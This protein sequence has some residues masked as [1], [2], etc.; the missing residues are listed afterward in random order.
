MSNKN[1]DNISKESLADGAC[2][3]FATGPAPSLDEQALSTEHESKK[4]ELERRERQL[5]QD[6]ADFERERQALESEL[7]AR[8]QG[9]ANGERKLEESR[10]AFESERDSFLAGAES[11]RQEQF[12][13]LGAEKKAA[14]EALAEELASARQRMAADQESL[15]KAWIELENERD[16]FQSEKEAMRRELARSL[17][18]DRRAAREA[19]ESELK[20]AREKRMA[21]LEETISGE[22]AA[23]RDFLARRQREAMQAL[24]SDLQRLR[25]NAASEI[26]ERMNELEATKAS[27]TAARQEHAAEKLRMED[28]SVEL[29]AKARSLELRESGIEREIETRC[30]QIKADLEGRNSML[31]RIVSEQRAQILSIQE[32]QAQY[33]TLR[34]RLGGRDPSGELADLTVYEARIKELS[35]R[36]ATEPGE[37]LMALKAEKD[38]EIERHKS[39]AA[40]AEEHLAQLGDMEER[41]LNQAADLERQIDDNRRL[42]QRFQLLEAHNA[43]IEKELQRYRMQAGGEIDRDARIKAIENNPYTLVPIASDGPALLEYDDK[44][45]KMIDEIGWLDNIVAKCEEYGFKFPKRLLYAF[46]TSLK[47]AEWSPLTV[48][49]GVSGTGKSELPRLYSLFGGLT[50]FSLPVQP[51][52]DSQEAMLG[53]FNAIDNAFDAQPVLRLLAQTQKSPSESTY[54]LKDAMTLIL[55]DEMNLAHMELY[56]AEF[57]SKFELRRG[58]KKGVVPRIDIK[59]GVNVKPYQ[60]P[61]GRNV[62]WVGTM[63][64]DETT[65][66]LS[67]KVLDRGMV[68]H[69]P[70]PTAFN[71]RKKLNALPPHAEKLIPYPAWRK[72]APLESN[73]E[74]ETIEPFKKFVERVNSHLEIAG[75]AL[76][77]R[78]WQSMEYYMACYPTVRLMLERETSQQSIDFKHELRIAFEDQLAQKIMPKLRGI[79]THG[80]T[81]ANCLDKIHAQLSDEGYSI[82]D[83]FAKACEAGYGQ[84]IWSSANYL[85]ENES[86]QEEAANASE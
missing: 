32:L 63:N 16:S 29:E 66:S 18:E 36:L 85:K 40:A 74:T 76:G 80:N 14:R 23:Q 8:K 43:E 52:W 60:L 57:L 35:E 26:Q 25:A 62:L 11:A 3:A 56:F 59:L 10:A 4:I 68:I 75:R 47:V 7:Q 31:A 50:F 37:A 77:H 53:F 86:A 79:E 51:N 33:D 9:L 21:Q 17:G 48:L 64:Q 82:A 42:A 70:R 81:R 19:L 61:L 83:D 58:L 84:F 6:K 55:L 15:A 39:R 73:L 12:Q 65:K 46:H 38:R 49:A 24:E 2:A 22:E 69:F 41:M 5:A 20:A 34:Q 71:R 44:R 1:T 30:E 54:G 13:K 27:Q 28:L 78:V 67:D 45:N 72:W